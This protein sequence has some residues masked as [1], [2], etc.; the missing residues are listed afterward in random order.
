MDAIESVSLEE[1]IDQAGIAIPADRRALLVAYR[2]ALFAWNQHTNLTAVRDLPGIDRRLILE[3]LRL[4][5]PIR[6]LP[7]IDAATASRSLLDLGTGGGIPGMVLAIALPDHQVTLMDSTGKKIAFIKRFIDE[8]GIANATA[9]Q[10]RAEEFGHKPRFRLQF[11]LVTARAVATLPVLLELGLPFLR[12]GG[13]LVLPKGVDL[14]DELA[15][16]NRAGA[17]L[18]GSF[19]S[20]ATLPPVGSTVDTRLVI[21]RKDA[22]TPRTYP[23][24]TGV[25]AKSPLGSLP[26]VQHPSRHGCSGKGQS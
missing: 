23:R 7:A 8:A 20:T 15:D 14:D 25:P 26:Q 2:D 16:G 1:L 4:V 19:V 6:D 11:D 5:G 21:V 3:S 17:I 9:I 13:H 18:G 24:R 12:I 22:T 10:G